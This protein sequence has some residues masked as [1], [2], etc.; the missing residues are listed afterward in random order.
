MLNLSNQSDREALEDLISGIYKIVNTRNGKIYIGSSVKLK[1][2]FYSHNRELKLNSHRNKILQRI[3][4]K[5]GNVFKFEMIE[6]CKRE[7]L[8]EREQYWMN[9]LN[10][11]YNLLP[12]AGNNTGFKHSAETKAKMSI[13]QKG[14]VRTEEAR[15][16]M[17]DAHKGKFQSE[18]SKIKRSIALKGRIH[19]AEALAKQK[20]TKA[21][22]TYIVS[23]ETKVKRKLARKGKLHSPETKEKMRLVRLGKKFP[24]STDWIKSARFI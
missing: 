11:E 21:S 7:K 2:R 13:A 12:V 6:Y 20:A 18:E 9:K 17:S 10:P 14:K 8:I 19:T 5:Y 1:Y 3:Y 24:R 22:R 16:N 4:N 23:D 15:K